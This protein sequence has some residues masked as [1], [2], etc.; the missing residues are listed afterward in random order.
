[1]LAVVWTNPNPIP[2]TAR[3]VERCT[4]V[5]G[6]LVLVGGTDIWTVHE[7]DFKQSPVRALAANCAAEVDRRLAPLNFV[8]PRAD[9]R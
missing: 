4:V 6:E 7:Q 3:S 8:N 2:R 1:M 5:G 9:S